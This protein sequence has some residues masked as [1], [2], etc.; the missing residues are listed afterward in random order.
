MGRSQ[1]CATLQSVFGPIEC[2]ADTG[3]R[4][5]PRDPLTPPLKPPPKLAS[6]LSKETESPVFRSFLDTLETLAT[7]DVTVLFSGEIGVGKSLA[8]R[9]LHAISG[10]APLPLV[11]VSLAAMSRGLFESELFGHERGA[12]T[13]AQSSRLGCFRRAEGGTLVLEDIDLLPLEV[14]VK[15]L[16]VLQERVVEPLG[17]ERPI[18]IDVRLMVTKIGRAHV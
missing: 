12:F 3:P 17:G 11:E 1:R 16:R 6:R 4:P 10:R 7:S 15:L 14:Q 5:P 2:A 9:R 8:A 18:P 13:D